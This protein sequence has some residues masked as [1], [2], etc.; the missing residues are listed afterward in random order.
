MNIL[1]HLPS[2]PL[3]AYSVLVIFWPCPALPFGLCVEGCYGIAQ[4]VE[5]QTRDWN[6]MGSFLGKGGERIFFSR[7]NFF[8]RLLCCVCSSP[9]LPQW[10]VKDAG[11]SARIE[12]GKFQI[13]MRI[14]TWENKV[15]LGWLCCTNLV[16]ETS[17]HAT[18]QET[19]VHSHLSSL[20]RCG[21]ILT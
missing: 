7:V 3:C 15:R 6:I 8:C 10:H 17:S 12:G 5:R 2:T 11:Q 19:L 16:W 13:S 21:L 20:S 9:V 14:R 1:T 18:R 4:L